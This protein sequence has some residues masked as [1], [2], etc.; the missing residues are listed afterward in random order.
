M[1]RHRLDS[2]AR[3]GEFCF[4]SSAASLLS[5]D[6]AGVISAIQPLARPPLSK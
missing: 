4:S 6:V 3:S 5:S 2:K 1:S